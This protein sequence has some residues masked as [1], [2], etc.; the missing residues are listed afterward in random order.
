MGSKHALE[1]P[2]TCAAPLNLDSPGCVDD[3]HTSRGEATN[4]PAI[5]DDLS[6]VA[7]RQ[8]AG[9]NCAPALGV[10]EK[11][12]TNQAFSLATADRIIRLPELLAI[13]QI[14]R[15]TAYAWQKAGRLPRS[16][17]LGPRARGWKLSDVARFLASL[18]TEAQ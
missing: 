14:S 6:H 16:V 13:L 11:A 1:Q 5:Y 7:R 2:L 4:R 8:L 9:H 3:A 18:G 10:N 12:P 17:A 15:T